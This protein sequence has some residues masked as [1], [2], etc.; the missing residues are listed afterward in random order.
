MLLSQWDWYYSD[1]SLPALCGDDIGTSICTSMM[2][3]DSVSRKYN[4]RNNIHSESINN[5][6]V[7]HTLLYKKN[8]ESVISVI[9]K[10]DWHPCGTILFSPPPTV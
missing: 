2:P 6:D 1:P 9:F 3:T 4:L 5:F 8:Q 10:K 7:L